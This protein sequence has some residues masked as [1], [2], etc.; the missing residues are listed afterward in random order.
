MPT[1]KVAVKTKTQVTLGA[2]YLVMVAL[3]VAPVTL[4]LYA[5]LFATTIAKNSQPNNVRVAVTLGQAVNQGL[6]YGTVVGYGSPTPPMC[7][8]GRIDSGEQCDP[9]GSACTAQC[10]FYGQKLWEYNP[11]LTESDP[12]LKSTLAD[13][14]GDGKIETLLSSNDATFE[15]LALSHT[16]AELWRAKVTEGRAAGAPIAVD[17]NGD[18]KVEIFYVTYLPT[19]P[20]SGT[21]ACTAISA[22]GPWTCTRSPVAGDHVQMT[23]YNSMCHADVGQATSP[24]TALVTIAENISRQG[25]TIPVGTKFSMTFVV[26]PTKPQPAGDFLVAIDGGGQRLW[27]V[28]GDFSSYP[29]SADIDGDNKFE[30]AVGSGKALSVYNPDGSLRWRKE[31]PLG[32][33]GWP[34]KAAP[35]QNAASRKNNL[36]SLTNSSVRALD[37]NGEELWRSTG[38]QGDT[39]A[40]NL[41]ND[42]EMEILHVLVENNAVFF[43]AVDNN[44]KELWRVPLASEIGIQIGAR[45]LVL[46]GGAILLTDGKNT[47]KRYSNAGQEQGA[48]VYSENV[49]LKLIGTHNLDISPADEY[50]AAISPM[51][52]G[53]ANGV[54]AFNMRGEKIWKVSAP[55]VGGVFVGDINRDGVIEAVVV[56]SAAQALTGLQALPYKVTAYTFPSGKTKNILPVPMEGIDLGSTNHQSMTFIRGDVNHDGKVDIADAAA[57]TTIVACLKNAVGCEN[58]SSLQCKVNQGLCYTSY[59]GYDCA[60]ARDANDDGVNDFKDSEFITSFQLYGGPRPP[61]PGTTLGPDPT[62]DK[63]DCLSY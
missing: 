51:Q 12:Y 35:V 26:D 18:G 27:Q 9:P 24:T 58:P 22:G 30:I 29:V 16:G 53:Y 3:V 39:A 23:V 46:E 4:G 21:M 5:A 40:A 56:S 6:N 62:S 36:L 57:N 25:C 47:V 37:A 61:A 33:V 10:K 1:P 54:V 2:A 45:P 42:L 50:L 48:V 20:T 59:G 19:G 43:Q 7:G 32:A 55:Y 28:E 13:I 38:L 63:L 60:D 14:N 34:S 49:R 41:D 17:A 11:Q 15:V 52:G 44:G 8:N 31:F